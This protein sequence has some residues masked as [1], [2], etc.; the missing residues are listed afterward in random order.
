MAIRSQTRKATNVL[1]FLGITVVF[2]LFGIPSSNVGNVGGGIVATVNKGVIS[3]PEY[4]QAV[5]RKEQMYKMFGN[6]FAGFQKMI[7]K[8]ALDELIGL[9]LI[10]QAAEKEGV[11]VTDAEVTDYVIEISAFQ[12]DGRFNK[13]TYDKLLK[14][15]K[16]TAAKFE[17]DIRKSLRN[18]KVAELM[19][20]ALDPS[21][22][23]RKKEGIVKDT[24]LKIEYAKIEPKE[25]AP[26]LQVS[27]DDIKQAIATREKEI[28]TYFD[29]HKM[30]FRKE[31]EV[32]ARH[33]LIKAKKSDAGSEAEAL[34]KITE[35]SGQVTADNFGE[36]ASKFSEDSSKSKQGDLGFFGRGQM[37][38]EFET[39]AFSL[40]PGKISAP[41]KSEFG[42]HL[43]KVEEKRAAKE[44]SFEEAKKE[45]AKILTL[46][47]KTQSVSQTL[48]GH[49][50]K[51]DMRAV[52]EWLKTWGVKWQE[53]AEFTL[54]SAQIPGLGESTEAVEAAIR[55]N[56][57]NPLAVKLIMNAG[58]G[59]VLRYKSIVKDL[60]D[61]KEP[62]SDKWLAQSRAQ[63][64]I[65]EWTK[66]L[67]D[68][69]DI[70]YNDRYLSE[71]GESS[72][73]EE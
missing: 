29:E 72:S 58:V 27:D 53:S 8:Q 70:A 38:P 16:L 14:N 66:K 68:R 28:I 63:S 3:V 57:D 9:E 23:E 26:K 19:K 11:Y 56:K 44:T 54:E 36:M 62:D 48:A 60:K 51:K 41:V 47:L 61:A 39:M 22:M 25:L 13:L 37:V 30:D 52:D 33:I 6:Q 64:A 69:A 40:T 67:R 1:L 35:I 15:N 5:E 45:I 21:A 43:I 10:S 46:R 4:K 20:I 31:E 12:V 18:G 73:G 34:K 42:Y 65:G 32:R 55:L 2:A 7:K 50:E 59:Y 17:G 71:T 49:L 24:K